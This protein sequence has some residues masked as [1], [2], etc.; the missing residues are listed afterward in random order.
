MLLPLPVTVITGF[1]GSGKT[2]LIN[3][4]L[5]ERRDEKIAVIENEFGPVSIDHAL[6]AREAEVVELN[7]GCVCCSVRGDLIRLL[8]DF[9]QRIDAGTLH[10]D[11]V[12]I[13]TTGLA[14]PA[15]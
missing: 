7:D 3:H 15:P 9:A 8:G 11:R 1:L 4:I 14:D 10:L 12:L 6:L 13:E 2:T 5:A